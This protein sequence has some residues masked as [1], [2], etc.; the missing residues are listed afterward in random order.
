MRGMTTDYLD[1]LAAWAATTPLDALPPPVRE[2]AC[3]VIADSL[4]VI[5]HGM[6]TPEMREFLARHLSAPGGLAT[7]S[8]SPPDARDAPA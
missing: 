3:L 7:G 4:G 6:Q 5:A 2:R 8:P 1:R